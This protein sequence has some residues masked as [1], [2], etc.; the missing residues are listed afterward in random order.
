[1]R[2]QKETT[3][4]REIEATEI[5][6][7]MKIKIPEGTPL[8][9]TQSLGGAYTVLTPYGYMARVDGKDADAIGEELT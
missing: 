6:S 8:G 7:G 2:M 3:T 1:M 4:T 5:P 9:I